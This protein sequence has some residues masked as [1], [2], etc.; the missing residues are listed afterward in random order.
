[1][2]THHPLSFCSLALDVD[3]PSIHRLVQDFLRTWLVAPVFRSPTLAPSV[4]AW[5]EAR[6]AAT[7]DLKQNAKAALELRQVCLLE[8]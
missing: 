7:S 2:R 3:T 5:Y 6:F 8:S 1:M 4:Y